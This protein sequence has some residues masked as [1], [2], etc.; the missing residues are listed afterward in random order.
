MNHAQIQKSPL[1]DF[2][3][4]PSFELVYIRGNSWEGR[5]DEGV[6][7]GEVVVSWESKGRTHPHQKPVW[8]MQHF[9]EKLPNSRVIL[10]PFMGSGTTGIA[11]I[12]TGRKFIGIEKDPKHFQTALDRIR[13]ELAQGQLFAPAQLAQEQT[14]MFSQ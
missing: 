7:R 14:V 9:I 2:P 12:R 10:D 6:L 3:W 11:C 5:R 13:R 8:L 1:P 4:K